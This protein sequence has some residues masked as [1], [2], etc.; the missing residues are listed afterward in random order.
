[1]ST[2]VY[3]S[4]ARFVQE[5]AQAATASGGAIAAAAA[6]LG[7]AAGA[8]AARATAGP[9]WGSLG[10]KAGLIAETLD[11][12]LADAIRLAEDEADAQA[13]LHQAHAERVPEAIAN[14]ERRV[15]AVPAATLLL[16][17]RHANALRSLVTLCDPH[18][19]AEARIAIH[20]LT[21]AGRAAWQALLAT[22]PDLDLQN[23]SQIHL[24][25]LARCERIALGLPD[26]G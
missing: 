5:S 26:A 18:P 24:D 13:A 16:C 19:V 21:G 1:M 25:D 17:A 6:A 20:L 2:P 8:R 22:Q 9:K 10:G 12:G 3:A 23:R 14:A 7:L 11:Q 15:A 4:L